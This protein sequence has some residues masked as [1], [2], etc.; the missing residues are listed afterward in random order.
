MHRLYLGDSGLYLSTEIIIVVIALMLILACVLIG[1][2]A[3]GK[4]RKRA[5]T[6]SK[7]KSTSDSHEAPSTAY[8]S[9]SSMPTREKPSEAVKKPT[10]YVSKSDDVPHSDAHSSSSPASK[11]SGSVKVGSSRKY[12]PKESPKKQLETVSFLE[13]AQENTVS[14]CRYCGAEVSSTLSQCEVCGNFL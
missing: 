2:F 5:E 3:I 13:F 10:S 1:V 14:A 6:D 4:K 9:S 8:G 11:S 12:V 7:S